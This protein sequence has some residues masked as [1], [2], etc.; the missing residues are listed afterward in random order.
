MSSGFPTPPVQAPAAAQTGPKGPSRHASPRAHDAFEKHLD[1]E[2]EPQRGRGR[3]HANRPDRA[4]AHAPDRRPERG[5]CSHDVLANGSPGP[6]CAST[7]AEDTA[8]RPDTAAA[9]AS[10]TTATA[11]DPTAAAASSALSV[12]VSIAG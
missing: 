2:L 11:P 6:A 10:T 7:S 3:A 9:G 12:T 1:R 4:D 5:G 8:A